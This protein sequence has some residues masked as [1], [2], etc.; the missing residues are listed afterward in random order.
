MKRGTKTTNPPQ[1]SAR[2]PAGPAGQNDSLPWLKVILVSVVVLGAAARLLA[3]FTE[4]WLDEIWTLFAANQL[5]SPVEIFAGF[6]NSNNHHLYTFFFFIVGDCGSWV[7]YRLPALL[8][9]ILTLPLVW[10]IGCRFGKLEAAIATILSAGSYLLIH[11]SSEARGYALVLFF[12]AGTLL[13]VQRYCTERRWRWA[14]WVWL[15]ACLGFLSQLMFLFAFVAAAI[16]LPFELA[17]NRANWRSILAGCLQCFGVPAVFIAFFYLSVIRKME[18]GGGP[19]YQL[20]DVLAQTLS[21]AGGGPGSLPLSLLVAPATAALFLWSIFRLWQEGRSEWLFFLVAIFLAPAVTL[22]AQR[23]EVLFVRYFLLSILFGYLA[24]SFALADLY[25]RS[26]PMRLVV[27]VLVGLFLVGNSVQVARLLRYGRGGYREAMCYLEQ[28]DPDPVITIA[29]DD[30]FRNR[31]II[32][33]Y[34][35]YLSP[36]KKIAYLAG[37][38]ANSPAPR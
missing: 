32:D 30:D 25:R 5:K 36:G 22:I 23:P 8:A 10:L 12:A 9:G 18:I 20:L 15:C 28:H 27:T 14:V 6:T 16:W 13:G 1:S 29:G 37:Y 26:R 3:C 7:V 31:M 19:P 17:K 34:Q 24:A 35:R 11:F 33:Y 21:Y 2:A 4:L 38:G